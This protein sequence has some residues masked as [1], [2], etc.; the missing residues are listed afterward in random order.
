MR[1]SRSRRRNGYGSLQATSRPGVVSEDEDDA[2][3][4]EG[5]GSPEESETYEF[6]VQLKVWR[7]SKANLWRTPSFD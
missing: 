1:R 6:D 7:R 4:F 5:Q 2:G 3:A